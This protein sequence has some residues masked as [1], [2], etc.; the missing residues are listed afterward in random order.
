MIN[1]LFFLHRI[2]LGGTEGQVL[3]LS[4]KLDSNKFKTHIVT[5]SKISDDFSSLVNEKSEEVHFPGFRSLSFPKFIK[6]L[7]YICDK[8]KI[9]VIQTHFF[10]EYMVGLVIKK[11]RPR[12]RFVMSKRNLIYRGLPAYLYLCEKYCLSKADALVANSKSV[13]ER[14]EDLFRLRN[15]GVKVLY[16]GVDTKKYFQPSMRKKEMAKIE[17]GL[18]KNDFV[19][20]AVANWREEKNP[21]CLLKAARLCS[22]YNN[23]IKFMIVGDGDLISEM[24]EFVKVSHLSNVLFLGAI[25]KPV[26]VMHAFD[27]GVSSSIAEGFS[28]VILEFMSLGLPVIVTDV[29]GNAEAVSHCKTGYQVQSDDHKA[30]ASYIMRLKD[31]NEVYEKM[32]ELAIKSVDMKFSLEK[33]VWAYQGF[34]SSLITEKERLL[35]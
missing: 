14:W 3:T 29:G 34:Y 18:S 11:L 6:R 4:E 13:K 33:M 30:M 10:H 2:A 15:S 12:I 25:T 19:V 31:E 5:F 8:K 27:I 26:R 22:Q 35:N 20:G 24:R 16:N 1:I 17:I 9:N 23:D 7:V 28:N 21:L 32:S